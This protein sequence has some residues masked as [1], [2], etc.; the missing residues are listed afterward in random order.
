MVAKGKSG[1]KP[2][3]SVTICGRRLAVSPLINV[4]FYWMAERH[5]IHQR[6]LAGEETWTD[7]P[8]L[9]EYKF[10]NLFR[11]FDRNTQFVLRQ[12]IPGG[13]S[14]LTETCFRVILFRMFNRIETWELLSRQLGQLTWES[15]DVDTYDSVLRSAQ[16]V[17][18]HAY[19]I[20]AP[21]LGGHDNISNH[22]RLIYL[23]MELELPQQLKEF[24]H[25]QDAFQYI[26]LFPGMGD[27]TGFQ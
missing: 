17:H 20:P 26:C 19:F 25:M 6:R 14:G 9:Q 7:D 16:A 21:K 23:L 27:F 3:T 10:T 18:G 1:K 5:S 8:I 15:F 24:F 4:L 13:E 2:P 12:V 11:I 22:L